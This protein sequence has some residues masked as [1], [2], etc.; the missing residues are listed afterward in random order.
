MEKVGRWVKEGFLSQAGL[1]DTVTLH[2]PDGTTVE[3]PGER[4]AGMVKALPRLER[5]EARDH[6]VEKLEQRLKTGSAVRGRL[7]GDEGLPPPGLRQVSDLILYLEARAIQMGKPFVQDAGNIPDE[8]GTFYNYLAS[9]NEA[10][11]PRASRA[12]TLRGRSSTT[13]R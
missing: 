3:Y 8:D 4:L 2:M 1:P 9:S 11:T 13:S 10:Y 12:A 6:L 5:A 7:M